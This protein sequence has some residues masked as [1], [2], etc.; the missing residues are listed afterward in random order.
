MSEPAIELASGGTSIRIISP[1]VIDRS[2][3]ETY[4]L[5]RTTVKVQSAAFHG[6]LDCSFLLGDFL[7]FEP[8]LVKLHQSLVGQAELVST[9]DPFRLSLTGNGRGEISATGELA[10]SW[11]D[12]AR[13]LFSLTADQSYLPPVLE[14]LRALIAAC[15]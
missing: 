1:R 10:D 11:N 2:T 14:G 12:G 13:L 5:I 9:E 4:R 3:S 15:R 6:L 7:A 8:R